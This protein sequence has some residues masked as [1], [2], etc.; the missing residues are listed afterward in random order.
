[1][2]NMSV[3]NDHKYLEIQSMHYFAVST[4]QKTQLKTKQF[5]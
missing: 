5:N 3:L 1:M 4:I 2:K